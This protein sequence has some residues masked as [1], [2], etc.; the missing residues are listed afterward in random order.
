MALLVSGCAQQ[1][2]KLLRDAVQAETQAKRAFEKQDVQGAELAA[3]RAEEAAGK[4]AQ[5]AATGKLTG[6]VSDKSVEQARGAAV[7]ARNFAQ[8][9]LED[10]Q[11]RELLAGF[12][13][14]T[15]QRLR[16]T[17]CEYG[18]A[19]P[20]LAAE[21]L[22]RTDTNSTSAAERSVAALAWRLVQLV[23]SQPPLTNGRPDWAAVAADLRSW[24]NGPPAAISLFLGAAFA[25]S[26]WTDFALSEIESVDASKLSATNTRSAYHVARCAL[27]AWHGWDRTAARE[28]EEA[29]RLSPEGWPGVGRPQAVA[30]F[31]FWLAE[32]ALHRRHLEQANAEL[33]LAAKEWPESSLAVLIRSEQLT[34]VGQWSA[35]AE[36]LKSEAQ[37]V[38]DDW[39][40]QRMRRRAVELEQTK[41]AAPPL[42]S[43]INVLLEIAAHS[44]ADAAQG[45]SA[46]QKILEFIADARNLGTRL[47]DKLPGWGATP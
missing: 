24:S 19:G 21:Q 14:K 36:L 9:A 23:D 16:T 6:Q 7:S 41:G 29:L 20:A 12:K 17:V 15:Y 8:L 39:M 46:A 22:A 43:D 1:P 13:L 10:Q 44:I 33:A 40:A 18:M 27:L 32:R 26:G 5:L 38:K 30:L 42:L 47:A 34:S 31:H 35:A 45:S 4:L 25:V 3:A 11:R 37:V 28:L 2:T